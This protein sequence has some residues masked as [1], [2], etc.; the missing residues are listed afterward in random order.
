MKQMYKTGAYMA[1]LALAL[2]AGGSAAQAESGYG[3]GTVVG[4]SGGGT[5][6]A[7]STSCF[8]QV[9]TPAEGF[10]VKIAGGAKVVTSRQV[11]L[12][13]EGGDAAR[14]AVSNSS[15]FD[16][17]SSEFYVSSK[18]WTLPEG[19]G[20]KTVYVRFYNSCGASTP[21][22]ST[23]VTLANPSSI[24][25][26]PPAT[27]NN[28]STGGQVLGEKIALV[29]ELIARLRF[30][31]RSED[32]RSLQNE[33]KRLGYFPARWNATNYYGPLTLSAVTRYVNANAATLSID[34]LIATLRFGQTSP[35]VRRLQTM[36]VQKGFMP[37][38]W[39]VTS[40]YGTVTRAGVNAYNASK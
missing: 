14:M 34:Q 6:G 31:Q 12:A 24:N 11:D 3:G 1:A 38:G 32:V 26:P 7:L 17:V 27:G 21:V 18:S 22:V 35:N 4:G 40:F 2:L 10:S 20:T 33:L 29:D 36:L 16:G 39:R 8:V 30:G 13:F 15:D 28:G 19:E 37:R 25:T 23:S 9:N 5:G